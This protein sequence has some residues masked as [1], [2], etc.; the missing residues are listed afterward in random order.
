MENEKKIN[1]FE[2]IGNFVK[3][4][5]NIFL[6]ILTLIVFI[7][8][9]INYFNYYQQSKNEKISE[10]FIQAGIYLSSQDKA[11]SKKIY[12]EIILSK[13][14]FYS[15]LALNNILDNELEQN[16]D[17]VLKLFE[18]IEDINMEREEKNLIKLKKA[19]YLIKSSRVDAGNKLLKEIISNKS[20]WKDSALEILK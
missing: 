12:K 2:Q 11:Q 19:L 18:V 7:L 10:K 1:S 13:N 9:G 20:I 5:K 16:S 15:F 8:I 3:K 6:A 4:N 17:E 14:K